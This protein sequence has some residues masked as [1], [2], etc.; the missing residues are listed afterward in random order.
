MVHRWMIFSHSGID[1]VI[2]FVNVF[3]SIEVYRF[4][5]YNRIMKVSKTFN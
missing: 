4:Y 1:K 2:R 3:K 5:I